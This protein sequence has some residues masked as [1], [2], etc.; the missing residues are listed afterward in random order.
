[1]HSSWPEAEY[2][3]ADNDIDW[4]PN[5]VIDIVRPS[6]MVFDLAGTRTNGRFISMLLD[7]G[8]L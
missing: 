2:W 8:A 6:G 1:M 7:T 3:A 4:V 5:Q